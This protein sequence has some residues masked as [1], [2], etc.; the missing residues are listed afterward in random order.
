LIAEK[1]LPA[2]GYDPDDRNSPAAAAIVPDIVGE[3]FIENTLRSPDEQP[4]ET[5]ARA[6]K[7]QAGTVTWT[8][9]NMVEG[10]AKGAVGD[11]EL[12]R[13]EQRILNWIDS[14]FVKLAAEPTL[15]GA[16]QQLGYSTP[17]VLLA[18]GELAKVK[19]RF[20][21]P[22]LAEIHGIYA[23][24][25]MLANEANVAVHQYATGLRQIKPL[26]LSDP[27]RYWKLAE[28]L[29]NGYL[30]ACGVA[31]SL[32]EV[33]LVCPF[34]SP[35]FVAQDA[36][37]ESDRFYFIQIMPLTECPGSLGNLK[38]LPAD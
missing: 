22:R 1:A 5:L 34:V 19:P 31:R 16:K 3:V 38:T 18:A 20:F 8:L 21:I 37:N 15:I 7:R 35:L 33:R 28:K 14:L 2:Q 6:F 36:I 13:R 9:A 27:D 26:A 11:P 32:A 25:L 29:A 30:S 23:D 12:E 24:Q 17:K 4:V 10:F